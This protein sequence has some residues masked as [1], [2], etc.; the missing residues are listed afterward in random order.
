VNHQGYQGA[1]HSPPAQICPEVQKVPPQGTDPG[2]AHWLLMQ[3]LPPLQ[4][5]PPHRVDPTGQVQAADV[6]EQVSQ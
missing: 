6:L 4:Q 5:V 1:Q 2:G 3:V